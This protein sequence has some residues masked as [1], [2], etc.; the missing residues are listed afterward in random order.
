MSG[1]AKDDRDIRI[2]ILIKPHIEIGTVIIMPCPDPVPTPPP[3]RVIPTVRRYFHIAVRP[4][5]LAAPAIIPASRFADDAGNPADK[6]PNYGEYGYCNCFIN[7]VMQEGD[8]YHTHSLG[9][10]IAATGQ[11]IPAGTPI[12]LEFVKLDVEHS[13]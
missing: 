12:I 8:L 5:H 2:E 3:C 4:I 11:T 6:L 1:S 7:G 10:V 13:S 9:L